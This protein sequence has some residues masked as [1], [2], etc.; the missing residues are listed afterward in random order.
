MKGMSKLVFCSF[1]VGAGTS[2]PLSSTP[3]I[4]GVM[5]ADDLLDQF[6]AEPPGQRPRAQ[7]EAVIDRDK[8]RVRSRPFCPLL[9]AIQ[10]LGWLRT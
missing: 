7:Q 5:T 4:S 2:Y 10:M 8:D 6:L 3:A 9:T 1:H